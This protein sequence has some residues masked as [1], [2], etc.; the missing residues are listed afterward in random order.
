MSASSVSKRGFEISV[1]AAARIVSRICFIA[2]CVR[3][4][5][6]RMSSMWARA[7]RSLSP[8]MPGGGA[9][10]A[11]LVAQEDEGVLV[12][13]VAV[14]AVVVVEAEEIADVDREELVVRRRRCRRAARQAGE[15]TELA[16]RSQR[17]EIEANR[18]K[19]RCRGL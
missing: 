11:C 8:T 12:D 9:V 7:R 18:R 1:S 4:M 15:R 16:E 17:T 10:P 2:F 19:S 14:V 6:V 5:L 13:G 3:M